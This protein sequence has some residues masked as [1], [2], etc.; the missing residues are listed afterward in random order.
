MLDDVR[1]VLEFTAQAGNFETF[2]ANP[3][4]RKGIVM[5]VINIGELS[6]RLPDEFKSA[7]GEIPWRQIAGMRDIAAH[8]YHSMDD[9]IIWDVATNSIP[10][11]LRFLVGRLGGAEAEDGEVL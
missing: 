2:S 8:G 6:K 10:E 1:D 4:Y 5:S 7:H 11:L 3:L 9:D